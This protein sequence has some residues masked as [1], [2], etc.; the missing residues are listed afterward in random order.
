MILDMGDRILR[1]SGRL[2]ISSVNLEMIKI[3][4]GN[5]PAWYKN[6]LYIRDGHEKQ[7]QEKSK[8]QISAVYNLFK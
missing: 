7:A 1:E 2:N 4:A 6:K 3:E 8:E 5:E